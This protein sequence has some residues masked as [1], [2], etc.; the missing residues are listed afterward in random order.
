MKKQDESIEE[1]FSNVFSKQP[2]DDYDQFKEGLS[3]K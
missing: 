2:Y 3:E 1:L